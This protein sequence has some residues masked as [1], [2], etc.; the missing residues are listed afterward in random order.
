MKSYTMRDACFA[1]TTPY[2]I[3]GAI[4]ITHALQLDADLY[5][6]GVFPNSQTVA[7]RLKSYHVFHDVYVVDTKRFGMGSRISLGLHFL[8]AEK[9]VSF[10][11]PKD[12]CYKT[13]YSSSRALKKVILM[14]V[15]KKRN[16]EMN[17]VIYEDGMG[18]YI[19]S[20]HPL[21]ASPLMKKLEWFLGWE[22]DDPK[23]T[24]MIAH[25][26]RLVEPP[27]FLHGTEVGQMP[28][29]YSDPG[30][31]EML[32]DV[33]SVDDEKRIDERYIL[34][35]TL[36]PN[37]AVMSD[38]DFSILDACYSRIMHC[39]GAENIVCK[40]HPR[41]RKAQDVG[42]RLYTSQEL[43]MEVLYAGMTDLEKRV[44]ISYTS[45]AMFTPKLLFGK[46]PCV[47]SLHRM[48]K[49]KRGSILFEEMYKKMKQEYS[50][51]SR[52][53]APESLDELEMVLKS[54]ED[55]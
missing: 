6:F 18:T 8:F 53:A 17:R 34:F 22:I 26:P 41:S 21:N 33:F 28:G 29:L 32:N 45:S 54:I 1:C 50:V 49:E 42:L 48:L 12:I 40:P 36:R 9:T 24:R 51:P 2:Q 23:R 35:D 39:V 25:V 15:L 37:P 52:I 31:I 38:E 5:I 10:F 43:P 13:F 11:L 30:T 46:E 55:I 4:E 44:L 47:I 27:A 16:P 3:I 14:G 19:N 20:S 7:D